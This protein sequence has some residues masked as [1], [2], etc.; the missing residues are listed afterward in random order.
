MS[1]PF[2]VPDPERLAGLVFEL[3][4]QLHVERARRIAL[5]AVLREAGLV[6]D[7]KIEAAAADAATRAAT[8][9]ALDKAMHG[10]MRVVTEGSDPR[11]PLRREAE[12]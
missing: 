6:S 11:T 8:A 7:E 4:S 10:L 12:A 3:A 9:A 5:E 2:G 1:A